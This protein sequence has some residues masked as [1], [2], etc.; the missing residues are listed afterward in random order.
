MERGGASFTGYHHGILVS[1]RIPLSFAVDV[2]FVGAREF[3]FEDFLDVQGTAG[4]GDSSMRSWRDFRTGW[5]D[6]VED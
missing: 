6:A 5:A 2:G 4:D 3:G 1:P